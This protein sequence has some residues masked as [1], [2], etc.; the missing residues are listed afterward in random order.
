M[1]P[2]EIKDSLENFFSEHFSFRMEIHSAIALSGGCINQVFRLTTNRGDFCLKYNRSNA[3][4][5]MFV[6]EARGLKILKDA[7][8][9]R[10]PEVLLSGSGDQY[11][12]LLM[13][14]VQ[15]GKA[16]T[17][18]MEEFGRSLARL[19]KHSQ[20]FFGE[21]IDNYMGSLPQSNRKHREW[22]SFFIEERLEKQVGIARSSGFLKGEVYQ[23]FQRLYRQ[24]DSI[25]PKEKPA[26]LHGDLWNGNWIVDENGTACLIDPAVYYGHREIDLAMTLLFGGFDSS[27]YTAYD[28]EFPLEK[29]WRMRSDIGNLYPL[30]IHLNLFGAGYLGQIESI[31]RKF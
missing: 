26:L 11:D 9:I 24:L 22:S 12:Y 28:E 27:F 8:E 18:L 6:A 23:S 20:E 15:S 31:I 25:F 14:F 3:Y 10:I 21:D 4:P 7:G 1:I 5:G 13:E 30:L 29:E 17:R 2:K 19:H 16:K